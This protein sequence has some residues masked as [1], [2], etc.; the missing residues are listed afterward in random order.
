MLADLSKATTLIQ[1]K[2]THEVKRGRPGVVQTKDTKRSLASFD[3]HERLP[4]SPASAFIGTSGVALRCAQHRGRH[5]TLWAGAAPIAKLASDLRAAIKTFTRS[6]A[7]ALV[8]ES[9]LLRDLVKPPRYAVISSDQAP[10][11]SHEL[12]KL[13]ARAALL[14]PDR[15]VMATANTLEQTSAMLSSPHL[16][17]LFRTARHDLA[18]GQARMEQAT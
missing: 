10:G 4:E 15:Y 18:F 17:G 1:L 8:I 6:Y 3:A 2:P 11:V 16:G 13:G 12:G 5:K 14:R 9:G 7:P